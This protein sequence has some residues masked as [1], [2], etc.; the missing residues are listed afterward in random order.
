M[1]DVS[2]IS[3]S[4]LPSI[5][6]GDRKKL[7]PNS[8]G[9]YFVMG[10]DGSV[11]YIGR[12]NSM[13]RRWRGKHA[14]HGFDQAKSIRWLTVSDFRVL[15]EIEV[16]AI[17]RFKPLLNIKL[18]PRE[19]V[20]V[21][22]TPK[23]PDWINES[24]AGAFSLIGHK[25]REGEATVLEKALRHFHALSIA[26]PKAFLIIKTYFATVLETMADPVPVSDKGLSTL[27]GEAA[28]KLNDLQK[29]RFIDGQ[30]EKIQR[31]ETLA[32]I[33][34]LQQFLAGLGKQLELKPS[35]VLKAVKN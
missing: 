29:A 11:L 9:V 6:F 16:A 35:G 34:A 26:D 13:L 14:G 5:P 20:E 28:E 31:E 12:A 33:S 32:I 19:P 3:L 4:G 8:P 27:V 23:L 2:K 22:P 21:I 25:Q 7:L 18:V 10:A 15:P 17:R 1:M 24:M 30:S